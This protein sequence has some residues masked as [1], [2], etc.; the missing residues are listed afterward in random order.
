ME[1]NR[2]QDYEILADDKRSLLH[3]DESAVALRLPSLMQPH[4]RDWTRVFRREILKPSQIPENRS[5]ARL[6]RRIRSQACSQLQEPCRER[7]LGPP[8]LAIRLQV[9][10]ADPTP[11]GLPK[12]RTFPHP[13]LP[14]LYPRGSPVAALFNLRA[15][16]PLHPC[17][18]YQ[19]ERPSL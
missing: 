8:L 1:G 14:V 6:C 7:N 11:P 4:Y 5:F 3:S 10:R 2:E 16:Q 12:A 15:V 13:S 19:S 18:P 17:E 9:T